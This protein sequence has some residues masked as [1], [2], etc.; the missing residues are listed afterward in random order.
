MNF[1]SLKYMTLYLLFHR[2]SAKRSTN[3][4]CTWLHSVL[5]NIDS[6]NVYSSIILEMHGHMINYNKFAGFSDESWNWLCKKAQFYF[7]LTVTLNISFTCDDMD[8]SGVDQY[9]SIPN[10]R[11]DRQRIENALLC[12]TGT[13]FWHGNTLLMIRSTDQVPQWH[14]RI[15]TQSLIIS[16]S[17]LNPRTQLQLP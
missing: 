2:M 1:L 9:R 7:V 12:E 13:H 16:S 11:A 5:R 10:F 8:F 3:L 6:N 17:S 15:R 14:N 4:N